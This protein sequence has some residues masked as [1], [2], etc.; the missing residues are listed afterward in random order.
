MSQMVMIKVILSLCFLI[1]LLYSGS[2]VNYY[3]PFPL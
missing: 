2:I 3:S 1:G